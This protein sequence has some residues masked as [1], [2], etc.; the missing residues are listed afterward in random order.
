MYPRIKIPSGNDPN[1]SDIK[2]LDKKSGKR[3]NEVRSGHR[4]IKGSAGSGK[5]LLIAY[6][7]KLLKQFNPDWKILIVCYNVTLRS[8]IKYLLEKIYSESNTETTDIE[9]LHLHE[10]VI[11]TIEVYRILISTILFILIQMKIGI[12]I[13]EDLK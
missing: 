11:N 3:S 2:V 5:T 4:I 9:V 7:A 12:V 13:N 8:Y 6:R 1:S 10:L